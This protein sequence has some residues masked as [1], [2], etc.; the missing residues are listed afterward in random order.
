M[1]GSLGGACGGEDT[2]FGIGNG[3]QGGP[4]GAGRMCCFNSRHGC[5]VNSRTVA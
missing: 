2:C 5:G 4:R 1:S 3:P